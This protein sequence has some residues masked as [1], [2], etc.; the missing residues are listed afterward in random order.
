MPMVAICSTFVTCA[1]GPDGLMRSRPPVQGPG[2]FNTH[3]R[4]AMILTEMF[5]LTG[6]V[7]LLTG[8]SKGMGKAMA[9]GLAEHGA[10]V[11]ISSR[12]L[13]Q[14]EA[15]AREINDRCGAE[16]AFA[17]AC[18]AGYKEQLQELVNATKET[19]G[20][21]DIV[22]GNAG[23]NPFYGSM[24]KIPDD[25]YDKIMST[26]V[27]SNLWLAQMV[28]PDMIAKGKG[29][30]MFTSSVGAH[31]ASTTLGA[32]AISKVAVIGL[33]RNLAAEFGPQGVRVNAICP[34]LIRTDFAEALWNNPEAEKR[35]ATQIPL[36]RLGEADDFKGIAVF[37]G[38]DASRYITGQALTVCGGSHM[39]A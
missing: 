6:K 16:R 12:K 29:S 17:M 25:A 4:Q 15:A 2:R 14:C 22:V 23:I 18:N 27:K 38:S 11:M 8:A 34:G 30:I 24:M 33:A 39:R 10:K 31:G 21:I 5:D 28:M 35:A 32:Y 26:N 3:K 13:D 36:R 19:L 20:T 9:T 1:C 7:A 37:L